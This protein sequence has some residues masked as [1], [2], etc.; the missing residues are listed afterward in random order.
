MHFLPW[1]TDYH[2]LIPFYEKDFMMLSLAIEK[3]N[4]LFYKKRWCFIVDGDFYK[5]K[6]WWWVHHGHDGFNIGKDVPLLGTKLWVLNNKAETG[7]VTC[8]RRKSRCS[9]SVW[10]AYGPC[11]CGPADRGPLNWPHASSWVSFAL[12]RPIPERSTRNGSGEMVRVA[13]TLYG[14]RLDGGVS[15]L[16]VIVNPVWSWETRWR[17][18]IWKG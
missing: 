18:D 17:V 8:T 14:K 10:F 15:V 13:C 12:G 16:S 6:T 11:R 9:V 3:Q 4:V 2:P 5:E 1:K 7:R